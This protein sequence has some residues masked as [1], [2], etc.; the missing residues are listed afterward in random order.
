MHNIIMEDEGEDAITAL[1]FENMGEPMKL[2]QQ[3]RFDMF[4]QMHQEI[5][6]QASHEQQM[7][8]LIEHM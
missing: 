2:P 6:R 1:E 7:K 4:V 5:H 8:D 3:N